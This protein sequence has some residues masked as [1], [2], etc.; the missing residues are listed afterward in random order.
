MKT[1]ACPFDRRAQRG[2]TLVELSLV[3][4]VFFLMVI[5]ILDFGQIMFFH[6]VIAERATFGAR[7]A[8]VNSFNP[9]DTS[10][11]KNAVVYNTP[12]PADSDSPLYGLQ[13]SMVTVTPLPSAVNLNFIE[14]R[15]DYPMRFFTPGLAGRRFT[16][17][18]RVVRSVEGLGATN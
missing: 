15:V 13:T 1:R 8:V 11:V 9:L 3:M 5:A 7:W 17:T 6:Q 10:N 2:A 16:K 18:Y 12:A 4:L 14:V